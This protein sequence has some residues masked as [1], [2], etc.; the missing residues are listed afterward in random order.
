M[1]CRFETLRSEFETDQDLH[2][3]H[4]T[5]EV[6]AQHLSL[7]FGSSADIVADQ[8]KSKVRAVLPPSHWL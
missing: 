1:P 7:E 3:L 8:C 5:W 2:H 4:H 6:L